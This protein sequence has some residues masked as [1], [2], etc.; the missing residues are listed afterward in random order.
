MPNFWD[1]F[2]FS[3]QGPQTHHNLQDGLFQIASQTCS[4]LVKVNNTNNICYGNNSANVHYDF[5]GRDGGS[6]QTKDLIPASR[7][8]PSFSGYK[9]RLS[10]STICKIRMYVHTKPNDWVGILNEIREWLDYGT[11]G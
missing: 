2:G 6:D 8:M 9:K 11:L 3:R 4:I 5:S 10:V 1:N 7:K